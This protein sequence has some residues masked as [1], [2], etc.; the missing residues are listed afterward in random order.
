VKLIR[1]GPLPALQLM[2]RL[3]KQRAPPHQHACVCVCVC[4]CVARMRNG[5]EKELCT[6]SSDAR[7]G[8]SFG[9]S[10]ASTEMQREKRGE[11][12]TQGDWEHGSERGWQGVREKTRPNAH[13]TSVAVQG[14]PPRD[15]LEF[16]PPLDE[17]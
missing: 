7:G 6:V 16:L 1:H 15:F 13:H 2:P 9:S 17:A 10:P 11:A 5:H 4:V 12:S 3:M 8:N 14:E